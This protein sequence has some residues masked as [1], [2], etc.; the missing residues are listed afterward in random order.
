MEQKT[1]KLE[2]IKVWGKAKELR[3]QFYQ[4]FLEAGEK[5]GIRYAGG[6]VAFHALTQ[7][8]G[9]DVYN[10]TGEPYGATAAWNEPFGVA[11]QEACDRAG[12]ARDLCAYLRNY[13]GSILLDK[14]VFTDGTVLPGWPKPDFFFA[15]HF[16]CSHAK[17][18]QYAAE[19]EGLQKPDGGL[20]V[21]FIDGALYETSNPED[22]RFQ[23]ALDYV[24]Q[25]LSEAIPWMEKVT[26]RKY[27]DELFLEA[28]ENEIDSRALWAQIGALNQV[29]PAPLE[30]KSMYSLYVFDTLCP[31]WKT[32]VDF[33]KELKDEVEDRVARGVGAIYPEKVRLIA[34]ASQP[35]W[36]FLQIF[37]F[38]AQ[39]F[40]ANVVASMYA[41]LFAAWH[42]EENGALTPAQ[43]LEEQ[44]IDLKS[45]KNREEA[46]RIYA[47]QT[48][49]GSPLQMVF[50]VPI[51]SKV[52]EQMAKDWKAQAVLIH[53]NRG[54]EGTASGQMQNKL[55]L[56]KLGI[57]VF[58]YEGNMGDP[59]DFDLAKTKN[60]METFMDSL[61]I[62]RL[63]RATS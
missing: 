58:T 38:L 30:E 5:G 59:R 20:P 11:A 18:Y 25:Q 27:N 39:E 60:K 8:L 50:S 37:R 15:T 51:R 41:L 23:R 28:A 22:E 26:G 62:E 55:E 21:Y 2:P 46:L 35:P 9:R 42:L 61:G 57:P 53:L 36:A 6:A 54:C 44:G 32:T 14:Y 24:V 49:L 19:L 1:Y 3:R 4:G 45:S 34:D 12:I 63:N 13:W 31:H 47:E 17:W 56:T 7:G 33:Y 10:L 29:V 52:L 48:L 16:C 40:G 43:T